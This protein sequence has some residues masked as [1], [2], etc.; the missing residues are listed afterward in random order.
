MAMIVVAAPPDKFRETLYSVLTAYGHETVTVGDSEEAIR[1]LEH[2]VPEVL[3]FDLSLPGR[4]ILETLATFRALAPHMPIIMIE[5]CP[6]RETEGR[7][8]AIGDPEVLPK[9]LELD[10]LLSVMTRVL[11]RVGTSG[12]GSAGGPRESETGESWGTKGT[13]ILIADDE[14]EIV[15]LVGEFLA[16]LGY[17]ILTASSGNAA[18]AAMQRHPP[19]LAL[20]DVYMPEMNGVEVLRQLKAMEASAGSVNVILLT[21]VRD[22]PLLQEARDLGTVDFLHKPVGL[23][24]LELAVMIKL[25]MNAIVRTGTDGDPTSSSS[26]TQEGERSQQAGEALSM[27]WRFEKDV[28]LRQFVE[29]LPDAIVV[30][31]HDGHIVLSNSRVEHLFGYAEEELIGRSV[32]R[33]VPPR[34]MKRH[35]G[36]RR[37]YFSAPHVG[38][39]GAGRGL[40]GRRKNGTELAVNIHLS[41]IETDSGR[42]AAAVMRPVHEDQQP[43]AARQEPDQRPGFARKPQLDAV[44]PLI[45]GMAHHFN[46]FLTI[47]IGYSKLILTELHPRDSLHSDVTEIHQA[48]QKITV[49]TRHLLAFSQQSMLLPAVVDLNRR[50]ADIETLTQLV[51]DKIEVSTRLAP[52]LALVKADPEQLDQVIQILVR[53]ACEAMPQGGTL[54]IETANVELT[55]AHLTR[56]VAVPPNQYVTLAVRDTGQGISAE[57]L[58]HIFEPFFTTKPIGHS[59][60]L[61]LAAAF[62]TITQS[63]GTLTVDSEPGRGTTFTIYLPCLASAPRTGG[64][65]QPRQPA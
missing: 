36:H 56:P 32:E 48:A 19:D 16:G 3:L 13:T 47:I 20:L 31:N 23:D 10:A 60:G 58:P 38:W 33:L 24:Q 49:L 57:T 50:V 11:Q 46:N 61:E 54:T 34:L 39:T 45:A 17:R 7:L 40:N 28:T 55:A 41:P 51:G 21:A 43:H 65:D 15:D 59:V 12:G 64:M 5:D 22:E 42:F 27:N 62:G 14:P 53:N 37:N 1:L 6:P 26:D 18:L 35:S 8:R 9:R 44:K 29:A 2:R 4:P 63:G 52:D 30:C 25:V